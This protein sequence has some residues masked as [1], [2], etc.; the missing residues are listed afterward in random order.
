MLFICFIVMLMCVSVLF[1]VGDGLGI[2]NICIFGLF[3]V[4][5]MFI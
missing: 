1:V 2:W 4:F 5:M 3:C